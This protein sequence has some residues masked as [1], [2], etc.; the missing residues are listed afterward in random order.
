[1]IFCL[2]WRHV[3]LLPAPLLLETVDSLENFAEDEKPFI[4]QNSIE[5]APDVDVTPD[6]LL[7]NRHLRPIRLVFS[8]I[9]RDS[10][11]EF[12]IL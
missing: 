12:S 7:N 1:M 6:P 5:D 3:E 9:S 8:M 4:S 2:T 10:F 11:A